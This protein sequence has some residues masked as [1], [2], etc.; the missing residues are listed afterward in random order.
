MSDEVIR[1]VRK[2]AEGVHQ[3]LARAGDVSLSAASS[4][5]RHDAQ[6]L[7]GSPHVDLLVV[8]ALEVFIVELALDEVVKPR[9]VTN[10]RQGCHLHA[11]AQLVRQVVAR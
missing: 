8:S 5:L 10:T 6:H 4:N 1:H 11:P 2:H 3:L 7:L 9:P